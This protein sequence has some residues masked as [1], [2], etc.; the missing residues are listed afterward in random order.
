MCKAGSWSLD[1]SNEISKILLAQG[2]LS[3]KDE[4][5][6]FKDIGPITL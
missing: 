1:Y 2:L 3:H 5:R 6:K 4:V